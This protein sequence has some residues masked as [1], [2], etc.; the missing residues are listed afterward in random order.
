MSRPQT[1]YHYTS[2]ETLLK[3]MD[4]NSVW[5]TNI[6]YLNDVKE[7]EHC[8]NLMNN[9]LSEF[10]R[11]CQPQCASDLTMA[12]S[13]I[14]GSAW[15]VP[16]V[17][18]FSTEID[19]L[20]QWRSYCPHGNGVSIGFRVA[21]LEQSTLSRESIMGRFPQPKAALAPVQY[22]ADAD[23]QM[24]D[25]IFD[26][27]IKELKEWHHLQS[28]APP[29]ERTSADDAYVLTSIISEK[30]S[31]VKHASFA[32]EVEY[33]LTAPISLFSTEPA[34]HFRSSRTTV[35]PYK[36]LLMPE[37]GNSQYGSGVATGIFNDHFIE[38]IMVGPTPNPDL[39]V[40]ALRLLFTRKRLSPLIVK[41]DIPYRDL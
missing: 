26:D 21:A 40:E 7:R 8:L 5:A 36:I 35:I 10:L 41:T 37:W 11:V 32:S 12:L 30:C 23:V 34:I 24:L 9:R 13:R 29:E 2:A 39:T 19:S 25:S 27:C 31:L 38:H 16:Y 22:L 33:R 28:I 3:I 4:T 18:S 20:P 14:D 17:A 6:R 1:V 15:H